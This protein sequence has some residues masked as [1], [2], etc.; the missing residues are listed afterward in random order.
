MA[1]DFV[2]VVLMPRGVGEEMAAAL[3]IVIDMKIDTDTGIT[4]GPFPAFGRVGDFR[5]PESLY[6][7]TLMFDGRMD[8]GAHAS[9]AQRTDM[10]EIRGAKL[11]EG[12][13]VA[14]RHGESPR[15]YRIDTVTPLLA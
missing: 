14:C 12:E 2:S 5:K 11:I 10:L 3:Q 7:F 6:P 9:D 8:Y 15:I 4:V 1:I 13:E